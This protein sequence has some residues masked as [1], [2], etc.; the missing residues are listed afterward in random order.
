[1]LDLERYAVNRISYAAPVLELLNHDLVYVERNS[2][3]L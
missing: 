1:M 2:G 3:S